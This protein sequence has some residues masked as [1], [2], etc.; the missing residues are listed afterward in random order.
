MGVPKA[1]VR[2]WGTGGGAAGVGSCR[3]FGSGGAAHGSE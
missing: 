1:S 3:I 2:A